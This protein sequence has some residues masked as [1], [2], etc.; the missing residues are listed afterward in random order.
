MVTAG[1]TVTAHAF[2]EAGCARV[3]QDLKLKV[4]EGEAKVKKEK[5]PKKK[6]VLTKEIDTL[7][8]K[9]AEAEKALKDKKYKECV[10]IKAK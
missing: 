3:A 4:A 10:A 9:K 6:E 7:K 5:D 8:A 1:L 2:N